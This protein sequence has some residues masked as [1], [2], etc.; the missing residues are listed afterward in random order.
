MV[1]RPIIRTKY[2]D[3]ENKLGHNKG[4]GQGIMKINSDK[5]LKT[6]QRLKTRHYKDNVPSNHV[7]LSCLVIMWPYHS[8]NNNPVIRSVYY[9]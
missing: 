9:K 8:L 2:Y 4:A 3:T 6:I 1:R 5:T 7:A